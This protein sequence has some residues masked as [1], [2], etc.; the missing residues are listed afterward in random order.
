MRVS[1]I[2]LI[3][4]VAFVGFLSA[5][6]SRPNSFFKLWQESQK[7]P[8]KRSEFYSSADPAYG[9]VTNIPGLGKV[10]GVQYAGFLNTSHHNAYLY[11]WF[12][13][14]Q[15]KPSDPIVVWFQGGP[16]CSSL[17]GLFSEYLGPYLLQDN[18]SLTSNPH[19]WTRTASLLVIDQPVGTG[20]SYSTDGYVVKN[21][22]DV[23]NDVYMAFST[24]FQRYPQYQSN[25]LFL[26][27]ESYAGHYI[28]AIGYKI[29]QENKKGTIPKIPLAGLGIGDGWTDPILQNNYGT[30]GYNTGLVDGPQKTKTDALYNDCVK[31]IQSGD[32]YKANID[33]QKIM[34]YVAAASGFPDVYDIR[35]YEFPPGPPVDKFFNNRDVRKAIF[36][37]N[38]PN[39]WQ[40]CG[41]QPNLDSDIMKS[42][43]DKVPD[44]IANYRV[45][46]Y[47]GQ[48]DLICNLAGTEYWLDSLDWPGIDNWKTATRKVWSVD[49][50]TAGFHRSVL[51]LTFLIVTGAGHM[52]PGDQPRHAQDMVQKFIAN[53]PF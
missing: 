46:I 48:F 27:G 49:G 7:K 1:F 23:A 20:L 22:D 44:L 9:K 29:L 28:P 47:N 6:K 12:Y 43:K 17:G 3:L 35:K 37:S 51:N 16:G 5:I 42:V 4:V 15:R 41:P 14:S 52:V 32:Y 34:D 8:V 21:E 33:C 36:G 11:Y 31:T 18:L 24:F 45:L 39:E 50:E 10:N 26:F 13:E 38:S 19:T 2:L 53:V 25:Q 40:E 30:F